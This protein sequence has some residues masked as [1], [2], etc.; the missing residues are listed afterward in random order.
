VEIASPRH[1]TKDRPP[2][3]FIRDSFEVR[4]KVDAQAASGNLTEAVS[5]AFM[6]RVNLEEV[7]PPHEKT[8]AEQSKL[9][10][11]RS[12]SGCRAERDR[13]VERPE[14]MN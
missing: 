8:S 12:P 13:R 4:K 1:E 14:M 10:K 5:K 6:F 3:V 11:N 2:L 9:L 7:Q